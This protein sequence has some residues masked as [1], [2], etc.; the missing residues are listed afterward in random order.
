M[1]R[2]FRLGSL[3]PGLVLYMYQQRVH[4]RA[5]AVFL[6]AWQAGCLRRRRCVVVPARLPVKLLRSSPKLSRSRIFA[7]ACLREPW[8]MTGRPLVHARRLGPSTF[9]GLFLL[10][11]AL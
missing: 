6:H 4:A 3:L 10:R 1:A 9:V 5:L 2:V 11:N 7:E 8:P